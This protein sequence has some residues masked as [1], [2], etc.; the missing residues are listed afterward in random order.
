MY[1]PNRFV[2]LWGVVVLAVL[3]GAQAVRATTVAVTF[4]VNYANGNGGSID[5]SDSLYRLWATPNTVNGGS[6]SFTSGT[7]QLNPGDGVYAHPTGNA[8]PSTATVTVPS[9]G[10]NLTFS[11]NLAGGANQQQTLP[12]YYSTSFKNNMPF[13]FNWKATL[14]SNGATIGSG[15]VAPGATQGWTWSQTG[16]GGVPF[17]IAVTDQG[18]NQLGSYGISGTD[19]AWST[20]PSPPTGTTANNTGGLPNPMASDSNLVWNDNPNQPALDSTLKNGFNDVAT[21]D[22]YGLNQLAGQMNALQATDN[23]IQSGIS[24]LQTTDQNG[25]NSLGTQLSGISSSVAPLSGQLSSI[26][27]QIGGMQSQLHGDNGTM[28][29]DLSGIQAGQSSMSSSMSSVQSAV[30]SVNTTL[31]G[32]QSQSHSDLAGV[33]SA[34]QNLQAAT[35]V[36]PRPNIDAVKIAVNNLDADVNGGLGTVNGTLGTMSSALQAHGNTLAAISSTETGN[37][38]LLGQ[39]NTGVGNVNS[40]LGGVA[41]D[42]TLNGVNQTLQGARSDLTTINTSLGGINSALNSQISLVVGAVQTADQRAQAAAQAAYNEHQ[43]LDID[44]NAGLGNLSSSGTANAA[45]VVAAINAANNSI[46]GKGD[47]LHND[48]QQFSNQNHGDLGAIN[49]TLG[50]IAQELQN[51]IDP[52]PN[53]DSVANAVNG[54]KSDMDTRLDGAN[55]WLGRIEGDV[56]PLH[57]DVQQV[58]T[59]LVGLTNEIGQ[60]PKMFDDYAGKKLAG[61]QFDA[62]SAQA[63]GQAAAKPFNDSVS[64]AQAGLN[65]A[66]GNLPDTSGNLDDTFWTAQLPIIGSVVT[67]DFNPLHSQWLGPLVPAIY[68]SILWVVTYLYVF[69]CYKVAEQNLQHLTP[70]Q[71]RTAGTSVLGTN[72]NAL[73]AL[74]MAGLISLALAAVPAIFIAWFASPAGTYAFSTILTLPINSVMGASKPAQQGMLLLSH[75]IPVNVILTDALLYLGFRMGFGGV[76]FVARQVMLYLVGL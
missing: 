65:N 20:S 72:T 76:Y 48:N 44:L 49:A 68:T 24:G 52:R 38:G 53:I 63:S 17:H 18:G 66:A 59:D 31:N 22:G 19:P 30:S 25:F 42:S 35:V 67:F 58:H 74:G 32:F 43:T 69:A 27:S 41:K 33:Q 23:Q 16:T 12:W 34:I 9:G 45:S 70:Y 15:S 71:A 8:T 3:A 14:D 5:V 10:G 47:T 4:T 51:P 1:A 7:I 60:L 37:N 55:G 39:I 56:N 28:I 40:T 26:Y 50:T 21:I 64:G 29:A 62:D 54:M 36:D 13:G 75:F 61:M 11:L 6:G 2:Y 46:S 73:S 57:T